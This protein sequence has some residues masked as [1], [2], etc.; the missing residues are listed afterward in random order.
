MLEH[1]FFR[2]F[3]QVFNLELPYHDTM[4]EYL[5]FI[6]PFIK[7][8]SLKLDDTEAYLDKY[9]LEVRDDDDAHEVILHVFKPEEEPIN[10]STGGDSDTHEYL[11]SVDGNVKKGSWLYLPDNSMIIK[12][13]EHKMYNLAFLN[14]DFL[15]LKE[16]GNPAVHSKRYKVLAREKLISQQFKWY[17]S[18]GRAGEAMR[19]EWREVMELLFNIYRYNSFYIFAVAF[20]VVIVIIIFYFSVF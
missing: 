20:L 19:L 16:A 15:I 7:N 2:W 12:N 3:S 10:T 9:W 8:K 4:E 5:D 13:F 1:P 17:D 14:H 6:I 11:Y 18:L